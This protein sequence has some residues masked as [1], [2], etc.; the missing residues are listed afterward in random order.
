MLTTPVYSTLG[1]PLIQGAPLPSRAPTTFATVLFADLHGYDALAEDL[2]P[3]QVVSLLEEYFA[4]L[5]DA[6]LEFGGQI[7]HL[8]EADLMAGFGVG[9]SRHTQILEA[10]SAAYAIQRRFAPVRR[11]WQDRFSIDAAVGIGIH[12]GELAIGACG[13]PAEPPLIAGDTTCVAGGLCRRARAGEILISNVVYRAHEQ[14]LA[15]PSELA[16]L[17]L[18]QVQLRGRSAPLD[19]WCA[20]AIERLRMAIASAGSRPRR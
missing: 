17:H 16:F 6:V 1:I 20:P 7:F 18:P 13:P 5:T 3:V 15:R 9:D 10:I 2:Q 4:L 11:S 19:I 14:G 12:R 8:A